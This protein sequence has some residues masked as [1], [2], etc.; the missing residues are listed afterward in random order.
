MSDATEQAPSDSPTPTN[1]ASGE[2]A[3]VR[4]RTTV[5]V[6]RSPKYARLIILGALVGLIAAMIL[7]FAF[8]ESEEFSQGQVFGFLALICAAIGV[9]LFGLIAIILDKTVGAKTRQVAADK[10]VPQ[11]TRVTEQH[12]TTEG[13]HE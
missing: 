8:P 12:T 13:S 6:R 9:A 4:T 1:T 11:A 7:T 5:A 3:E 10:V 2:P